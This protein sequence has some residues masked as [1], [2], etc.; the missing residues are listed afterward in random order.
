MEEILFVK[1]LRPNSCNLKS[2]HKASDC[3]MLWKVA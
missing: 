1:G 3:K 2:Y